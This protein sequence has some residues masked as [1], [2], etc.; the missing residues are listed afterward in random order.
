MYTCCCKS[1]GHMCTCTHAAVSHTSCTEQSAP[2]NTPTW[3][4]SLAPP[5]VQAAHNALDQL[6]VAAPSQPASNAPQQLVYTA[7]PDTHLHHAGGARCRPPPSHQHPAA[8][9]CG[10]AIDEAHP[11][12]T[13]RRARMTQ[14][15]RTAAA[16]AALTHTHARCNT[17]AA[18]TR[19]SCPASSCTTAGAGR[20]VPRTSPLMMH[21]R[22]AA[23]AAPPLTRP[24]AHSASAAP[25]LTIP[26]CT[27]S[28]TCD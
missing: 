25:Q 3:T 27:L 8:H 26:P 11:C 2:S 10:R 15:G 24:H 7:G 23:S 9:A 28:N 14:A 1:H 18:A 22:C 16:P 17:Q 6:H 12:A 20:H 19:P 21:P 13:M 4:A 5:P